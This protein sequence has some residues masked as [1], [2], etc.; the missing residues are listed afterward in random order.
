[1]VDPREESQ[2]LDEQMTGLYDAL[3]R[4]DEETENEELMDWVKQ[5]CSPEYGVVDGLVGNFIDFLDDKKYVT[6]ILKILK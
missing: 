4:L 2:Q 6:L 3:L 1:M 5:V